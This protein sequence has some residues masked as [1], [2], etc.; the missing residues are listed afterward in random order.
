VNSNPRKAIL[1]DLGI[2]EDAKIV[3]GCGS[4]EARKG[5]DIFLKV[6]R[7][8]R[9]SE[10]FP[11]HFIWIGGDSESVNTMR[12][13]VE[14]SGMSDF[15][16]FVG[17]KTDVT[18]HFDAADLFLLTS[19]EDPFPLVMLEAALRGKAIVCFEQSGGAPEFV[20]KDAGFVVRDTDE[21]TDRVIETLSSQS[22]CT[23]LGATGRQKVLTN[24]D[25]EM[26]A[27]RIA[28]MIEEA[29]LPQ[30]IV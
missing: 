18:Q 30:V 27:S 8:A 7:Q 26:G 12:R 16:H 1:R 11:I 28:S 22:L 13:S 2:P 6:A 29:F 5:V 9:K 23:R 21:M 24:H 4:I 3:C 19:R 14:S 10:G 17:H 20:G 25:L 15:V